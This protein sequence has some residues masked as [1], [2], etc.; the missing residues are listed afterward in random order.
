[1]SKCTERSPERFILSVNGAKYPS[2]IW[3]APDHAFTLCFKVL[4]M[5]EQNQH[6]YSATS[7]RGPETLQEISDIKRIMERSS[8]FISLSG[9]SGIAA[10]VCALVGAYFANRILKDYYVQ[11]D[12]EGYTD[13]HFTVLKIK[14][15]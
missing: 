11:Y 3:K 12:R 5:S 9:L 2:K 4:F 7:A 14:L 6:G 13:D 1:M 10:G 15:V 8:R